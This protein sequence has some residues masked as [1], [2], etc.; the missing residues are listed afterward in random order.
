MCACVVCVC[1]V[2][3]CMCVC[4]MYVVR[5][6]VIC[7]ISM[8]HYTEDPSMIGTRFIQT[9]VMTTLQVS[10]EWE[11]SAAN[12]PEYNICQTYPQLLYFPKSCEVSVVVLSSIH[13]IDYSECFVNEWFMYM[14]LSYIEIDYRRF[15]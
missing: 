1:V 15:F 9:V 13:T 10:E 3:A 11:L 5:V 14:L 7:N 12:G 2:C 4:S 8:F 6:C